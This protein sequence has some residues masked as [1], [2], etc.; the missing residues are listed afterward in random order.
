[1]TEIEQNEKCVKP[2]SARGPS[3]DAKAV[4]V[5]SFYGRS[6]ILHACNLDVAIRRNHDNSRAQWHRKNDAPQ[7]DH[8]PDRSNDR[9]R[10]VSKGKTS[11]TRLPFGA[12][13]R[14]LPM[15]HKG[16]RSFPIS[17][18]AITSCWALSPG[19]TASRSMPEAR[20]G[21]V[22]LSHRQSRPPRRRPVRRAA[23]ATRYR[24]C[25]RRRAENPFARR[26]D[27]RHSAEHRRRNRRGYSTPEPR[28]STSRSSSSNKTSTSHAAPR[29]AS[30][31]W[32]REA[33]SLRATS[34]I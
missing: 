16:A 2:I 20:A 14:A 33:S 18:S 19:R 34:A 11:P 3:A 15:C 32:K 26:A 7:D 27:R 6:H 23:A 17:P 13:A 21:A 10:S 12:R 29:A 4:Q 31:L 24:A 8:G 25:A 1:M 5:D 30:P 28:W 9:R 22:S